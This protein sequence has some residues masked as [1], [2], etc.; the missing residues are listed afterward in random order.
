MTITQEQMDALKAE[1]ESKL[2]AKDDE[3][4]KTKSELDKYTKTKNDDA[5]SLEEKARK[6]RE[7]KE[8]SGKH[9]KSLES[10]ITFNNSTKDFLKNNEGLLPKSIEGIFQAAEKVTYDSA[11]QKANEI[12]VGIF[13]EYFKI[14]ENLKDL[15]GPQKIEVDAFLKLSKTGKEQD[16]ERVYSMIFEPVLESARKVEKARQLNNG[17]KNQTEGE[18]G[19]ADKMMK[20]SQKHYG[21]GAKNV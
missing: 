16:I 9:E 21:I 10:A 15:T 3:H 5:A 18:K 17:H 12:K 14:E 11:I 19:F 13:S 4:V 20:M 2:K 8:K 6:D 1:Y 7:D